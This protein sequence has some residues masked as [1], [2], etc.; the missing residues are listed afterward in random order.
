MTRKT[1]VF[2][3]TCVVGQVPV[4]W[5]L[6]MLCCGF[7]DPTGGLGGLVYFMMPL[8]FVI[9]LWLFSLAVFWLESRIFNLGEGSIRNSVVLSGV[10]AVGLF[11]FLLGGIV[12]DIYRQLLM[13]IYLSVVATMLFLSVWRRVRNKS[14]KSG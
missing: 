3:V 10:V 2:W 7:H 9:P 4:L 5:W 13:G 14:N 11:V 6:W 8:F 1:L 12:G